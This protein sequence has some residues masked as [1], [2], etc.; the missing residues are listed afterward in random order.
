MYQWGTLLKIE[1]GFAAIAAGSSLGMSVLQQAPLGLDT[2]FV[3][4]FGAAGITV[5]ML[6]LLLRQANQR[7]DKTTELLITTL[8]TTLAAANATQLQVAEQM[9]DLAATTGTLSA[10]IDA[11]QVHADQGRKEILETLRIIQVGIGKTG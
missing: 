8:N 7:A 4:Y 10:K 1:V 2:E 3:K 9:R 5:C 11:Y 6:W